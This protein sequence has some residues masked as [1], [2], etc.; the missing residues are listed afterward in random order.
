MCLRLGGPSTHAGW[1]VKTVWKSCVRPQRL[2]PLR[3][4]HPRSNLTLP[5]TMA[6]A[7]APARAF[8]PVAARPGRR[9]VRVQAGSALTLPDNITKVGTEPETRR[10]RQLL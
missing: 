2:L 4:S 1:K 8:R 10:R 5:A 9:A 3:I 7:I 6:S